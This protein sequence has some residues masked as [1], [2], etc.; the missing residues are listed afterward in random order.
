M[1][2]KAWLAVTLV[3][4]AG[5]LAVNAAWVHYYNVI[6]QRHVES[7]DEIVRTYDRR[8]VA[9]RSQYDARLA[10]LEILHRRQVE[11]LRVQ[12]EHKV[13]RVLAKL[14][15]MPLTPGVLEARQEVERVKEG[16]PHAD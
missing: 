3:F 13:D 14:D 8:I 10:E 1:K 12:I 5:A 9:I 2:A 16:I 7:Y 4:S 6:D 15:A 11:S